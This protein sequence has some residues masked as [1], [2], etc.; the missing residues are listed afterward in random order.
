MFQLRH[1][2]QFQKISQIKETY[3]SIKD[4]AFKH[5]VII[6][7]YIYIINVL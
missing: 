5:H 3:D 1:S 2:L 6:S 4:G 7:Q